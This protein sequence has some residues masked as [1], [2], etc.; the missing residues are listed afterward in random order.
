MGK[1]EPSAGPPL[2]TEARPALGEFWQLHSQ[3]CSG[4]LPPPPA[5]L[6]SR[7]RAQSQGRESPGLWWKEQVT[8]LALSRWSPR[9]PLESALVSVLKGKGKFSQ[10]GRWA[11]GLRLAWSTPVL[12]WRA[13]VQVLAPLLAQLPAKC[14]W[15]AA[16][17]GQVLASL[18]PT[19]RPGPSPGLLA[20][21]CCGRL[22]SEPAGRRFV[23]SLF[24]SLCLSDKYKSI[25]A[26]FFKVGN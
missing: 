8:V 25:N 4:P 5:G 18:P 1:A 26:F 17:D 7:A 3:L 22:G 13:W 16:G 15:G 21:G 20:P 9:W 12:D 23:L 24:S 19:W 10:G 6:G 11:Q 2:C 14:P